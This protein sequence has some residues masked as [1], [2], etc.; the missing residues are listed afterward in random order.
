MG[1]F[2]IVLQGTVPSMGGCPFD[3]S[4]DLIYFSFYLVSL[5]RLVAEV[6]LR[7]CDL[8]S[9][10][11]YCCLWF[12]DILGV[13]WSESWMASLNLSISGLLVFVRHDATLF[14][15]ALLLWQRFSLGQI[16]EL[17]AFVWARLVWALGV[18]FFCLRV[19][20]DLVGSCVICISL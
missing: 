11:L 5:V 10:V 4:V 14:A 19:I 13:F 2:P 8:G 3:P 9:V 17:V 15:A 20:F 16:V 12:K 1:F 6:L 18:F 7:C